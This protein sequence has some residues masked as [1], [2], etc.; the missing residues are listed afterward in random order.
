MTRPEPISTDPVGDNWPA[1]PLTNPGTGPAYRRAVQLIDRMNAEA[2]PGRI[3]HGALQAAIIAKAN[4][5]DT[6]TIQESLR[7]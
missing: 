5:I 2:G 1:I 6:E 7:R 4:N 3:L